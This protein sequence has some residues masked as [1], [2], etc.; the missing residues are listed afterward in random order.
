MQIIEGYSLY[1]PQAASH[2][3]RLSQYRKPLRQA[4]YF[5]RVQSALDNNYI[6]HRFTGKRISRRRLLKNLVRRI[7][8][9][10]RRRRARLAI[11]YAELWPGLPWWV[12]KAILPKN[13][14]YDFDDATF[15]SHLNRKPKVLWSFSKNKIPRLIQNAKGV[16][17][18]NLHLA[19]Y[20]KKYNSNVI[21]FPSVVNPEIHKPTKN[22]VNKV[23]T[24]GWVGSPSTESYLQEVIN[25]LT[26]LA[27]EKPLRLVVIGGNIEPVQN[28]EVIVKK[29]SSSNEVKEINSFDVG[30]M[31]IPKNEW[32]LG[33]CAFKAIT[34]MSCGKPVVATNYGTNKIIVSKQVGFLANSE[35]DWIHYLR[36]LREDTDLRSKM[37]AAGRIRVIENLSI[38]SNI[39]ILVPFLREI[40]QKQETKKT[41]LKAANVDQRTVLSFGREWAR[42]NQSSVRKAELKKI[43][44]M[45]F[46][47]FPWT[48]LPPSAIGCD[49]GCGS[50]RWARFVAPRVGKLW[51][52]DAS[53]EALEVARANLKNQPNCVFQN[54]SL[55]ELGVLDG[56]LDFAYSL[57]VLHHLPDPEKGMRACVQKLKVGAPFLVYLYQKISNTPKS[58]YIIFLAVNF[59]RS[60]LCML[61]EPILQRCCDALAAFVYWPISRC[62]LVLEKYG[63]D[64]SKHP[65][66]FY[67][68]LSF[69]TMR[70]DARD[71]FGTPLEKRFSKHEMISMM[72]DC[73]L[74]KIRFNQNA[75]FWTAIGYRKK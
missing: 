6:R 11:L 42:F 53:H 21:V 27:S 57:G 65:L 50:G 66:S 18:G 73:G 68:N 64:V 13:Y 52:I 22:S 74:E 34:Y 56:S 37:G 3:V 49:F 16:L 5:L 4:G 1:G 23:F 51:C 12:E 8:A 69:Y 26:T 19:D 7:Y 29:W 10:S 25:A 59:I 67:R 14:I 61:P 15:L 9:A 2:R 35:A 17:A 58:R 54:A 33:K 30:I 24:V 62:S 44:E 31:P 55:E 72:K 32:A 43:W 36:V 20:A 75:P 40:T 45:Y 70:T 28:V 71:R 39:K 63:L 48:R 41:S 38:D 60:I 46:L 47:N